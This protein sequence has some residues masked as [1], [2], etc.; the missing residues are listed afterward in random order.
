M[1]R[2]VA[3]VNDGVGGPLLAAL[4]RTPAA[5][6]AAGHLVPTVLSVLNDEGRASGLRVVGGLAAYTR[7]AIDGHDTLTV[8]LD[9]AVVPDGA[10]SG[11]TTGLTR[12][13][14]TPVQA[15]TARDADGTSVL[16]LTMRKAPVLAAGLTPPPVGGHPAPLLVPLGTAAGKGHRAAVVYTNLARTGALLIAGG[17][18]GSSTLAATLLADIVPQARPSALRLLVATDDDE[19]RRMLPALDH[20]DAPAVD[21]EQRQDVAALVD[22]ANAIVLER[23]TRGMSDATQPIYVLV[24]SD[25]EGLCLDPRVADRLDTICRNGADCGVYVIGTTYDVAALADAGMLDAF[26]ARLARPLPR[27]E[28]VTL[29]D[30][31]RA[32]EL[33]A[34]DIAFSVGPRTDAPLVPGRLTPFVTT[35]AEAQEAFAWAAKALRAT[36]VTLAPTTASPEAPPDPDDDDEGPAGTKKTRTGSP[37]AEGDGSADS[38]T[39]APHDADRADAGDK[40][41]TDQAVASAAFAAPE[42]DT[43]D[44]AAQI[45]P[46]ASAPDPAQSGKGEETAPAMPVATSATASPSGSDDLPRGEDAAPEVTGGSHVAAPPVAVPVAPADGQPT[47]DAALASGEEEVVPADADT[48][49]AASVSTATEQH[50]SDLL[51]VRVTVFGGINV[52]LANGQPVPKLKPREQ[53][54]LAALAI[55]PSPVRVDRLTSTLWPDE[56]EET[57]KENLER[58]LSDIRAALARVGVPVARGGGNRRAGAVVLTSAGYK[59]DPGIIWTDTQRFQELLREAQGLPPDERGPALTEAVDLYVGDLCG[60]QSLPWVDDFTWAWRKDFVDALYDVTV[61]TLLA[62]DLSTALRHARRLVKEE[63]LMERHHELLFEVL[64][65]RGDRHGLVQAYQEM[66][67]EFNGDGDEGAGTEMDPEIH[68]VYNRLLETARTTHGV[69]SDGLPDRQDAGDAPV[70]DEQSLA[71]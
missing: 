56:D 62:G 30:D 1:R 59:V 8:H 12:R 3:S 11:L 45:V 55:L 60:D 32:A 52:T 66:C 9:A 27:E 65:R 57:A 31:A 64:A 50:G 37:R 28:S 4:K 48:A 68:Q 54:L 7:A 53:R 49:G 41:G 58:S 17:A 44:Q 24:L 19:L 15:T 71:G 2:T 21:V 22:Q 70:R 20:L 23:F 33:P 10:L 25:V 39:G 35:L 18:Q 26:S 29:F 69:K 13:L 51:P 63:P 47:P 61:A 42:T 16:T 40:A 34:T 14:G 46:L 36:V 5:R 67:A 6:V 43:A 38:G